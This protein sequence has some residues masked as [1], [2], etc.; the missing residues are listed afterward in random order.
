MASIS[1]DLLVFH[2]V[3]ASG[4]NVTLVK[5]SPTA[6]VINGVRLYGWYIYNSNAS[7][8]KVAFH[9]QAVTPTAGASVLFSIVIPGAS[10][11]NVGFTDAIEFANGLGISTT[12]GFNDNDVAGVAASDLIINLFYK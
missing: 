3:S 4:T 5:V 2:L 12:T 10:A 1:H 9:D 11:A 6:P 7:A 8:R